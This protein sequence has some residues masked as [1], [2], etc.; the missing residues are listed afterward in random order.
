MSGFASTLFAT[1]CWLIPAGVYID[2]TNN[3]IGRAS[4]ERRGFLQGWH[5][6]EWGLCC[7]GMGPVGLILYITK[8]AELVRT[9][10]VRAVNIR[11][12]HRMIV[13]ALLL[14]AALPY[15]TLYHK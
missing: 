11:Y 5:A 9:A 7:I 4:G 10:N 8:R 15:L 14:L 13:V 6:G 2:A 12:R 3:N 1:I